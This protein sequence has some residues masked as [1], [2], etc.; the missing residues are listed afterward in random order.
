MEFPRPILHEIVELVKQK[1]EK[2]DKEGR[3]KIFH[4]IMR[5]LDEIRMGVS[6]AEFWEIVRS[7]IRKHEQYQDKVKDIPKTK[8]T[9][10]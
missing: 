8:M 2:R 6:D 3:R 5:E 10:T 9:K 4:N 1:Q 7:V